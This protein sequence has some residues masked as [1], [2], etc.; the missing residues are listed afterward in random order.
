MSN[1]CCYLLIQQQ[2]A[3]AVVLWEYIAMHGPMDV[4]NLLNFSVFVKVFV[5]VDM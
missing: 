2:V 5:R 1:S 3:A 4:K